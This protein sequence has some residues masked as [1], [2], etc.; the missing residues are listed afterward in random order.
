MARE[1]DGR[2]DVGGGPWRTGVSERAGGNWP[3][4]AGKMEEVLLSARGFF[5]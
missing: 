4:R 3:R 2:Q 5:A 1:A